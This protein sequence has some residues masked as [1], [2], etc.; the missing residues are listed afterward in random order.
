MSE[1]E[2]VL[3][4]P[5]NYTGP[6]IYSTVRYASRMIVCFLST[7]CLPMIRKHFT[8]SAYLYKIEESSIASQS[9]PG[10]CIHALPKSP[11]FI[12]YFFFIFLV[13]HRLST[14]KELFDND[15]TSVIFFSLFFFFFGNIRVINQFF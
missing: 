7:L 8:F 6:Y 12:F 3:L 1:N 9:R 15:N 4:I 11:I 2:R 14:S 5:Y 10:R 13:S